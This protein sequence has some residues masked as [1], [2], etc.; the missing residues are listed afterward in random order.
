M[1][2][3]PTLMLSVAMLFSAGASAQ[4]SPAPDDTQA[5]TAANLVNQVS[6]ANFKAV[7][8]HPALA[9][10]ILS[11]SAAAVASQMLQNL[12]ASAARRTAIADAALAV[13]LK[14]FN[15]IDAKESI[16][17]AKTISSDQANQMMQLLQ[18]L[19]AGGVGNKSMMSVP[20][21]SVP[22]PAVGQ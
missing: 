12:A 15:T 6:A 13:S 4:V 2:L 5:R 17:L 8:E 10:N 21:V 18:A 7:A 1:K 14:A 3:I 20:P 11:Q 9:N 19:N 16:S 22:P